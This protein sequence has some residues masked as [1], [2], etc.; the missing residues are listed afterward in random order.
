MLDHPA[1]YSY[2]VIIIGSGAAGSAVILSGRCEAESL[3]QSNLDEII[4]V[5]VYNQKIFNLILKK[6]CYAKMISNLIY[7]FPK[8]HSFLF[9]NYGRKLS[10]IITDIFSGKKKY[11]TLFTSVEFYLKL[12][13]YFLN[14]Q[15]NHP[16]NKPDSQCA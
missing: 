15:K 1:K 8:L 13:K 9:A 6:R 14:N 4:A 3:I 7:S 10:E 11:S 5:Q 16:A 2:D 12:I